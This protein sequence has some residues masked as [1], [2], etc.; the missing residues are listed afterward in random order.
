MQAGGV[1]VVGG[2]GVTLH[3]LIPLG[4]PVID[5]CKGSASSNTPKHGIFLPSCDV[6]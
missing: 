4:V 2:A 3:C 6:I 1:C 5:E